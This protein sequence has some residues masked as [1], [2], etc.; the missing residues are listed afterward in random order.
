M[1]LYMSIYSYM[2]M[3]MY[4]E[5]VYK[6]ICVIICEY[7]HV[8]V[9]IFVHVKFYVYASGY[10]SAYV[11]IYIND[12]YVYIDRT[13]AQKGVLF[14]Q[15]SNIENFNSVGS[16]LP[17]YPPTAGEVLSKSRR[18]FNLKKNSGQVFDTWGSFSTFSTLK[19]WG[20]F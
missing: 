16:R 5:Y 19:N 8:N 14:V 10:E 15:R 6:N 9:N 20:S 11:S 18:N 2:Y 1:N 13:R 17:K 4:I 7:V 12:A 3:H